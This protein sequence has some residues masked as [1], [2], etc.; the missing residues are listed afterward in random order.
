MKLHCITTCVGYDDFL[1]HT[2]PLNIEQVDQMI[3]VTNHSDNATESL[4][5]EHGAYLIKTPGFYSRGAKFNKGSALNDAL[6]NINDG[7]ILLTDADTILPLNF[8]QIIEYMKLKED[9]IY[10]SARLIC[11]NY[12]AY[13]HW[14]KDGRPTDDLVKRYPQ[15]NWTYQHHRLR[16]NNGKAG[17][18]QLFSA[19]APQL[20]RPWYPKEFDGA[21]GSD[22]AFWMK[23]W[24][25]AKRLDCWP[26]ELHTDYHNERPDNPF[27]QDGPNWNGR[28]TKR[29]GE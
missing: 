12:K 22:R 21:G 24:P 23:F 15:Y 1:A 13:G 17:Y 28:T 14:I 16:G 9:Y 6:I 29:F 10:G 7:W 27:N 19:N 2:L 4:A 5:L 18:L 25:K 20:T 11:P 3:V 8:R 26:V